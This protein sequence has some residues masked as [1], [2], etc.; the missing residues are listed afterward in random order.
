MRA[1][2]SSHSNNRR[3]GSGDSCATSDRAIATGDRAIAAGVCGT[4]PTFA[5]SQAD[6]EA[7]N[8]CATAGQS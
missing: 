6:S 3:H 4:T 8:P 1:T 5:A 7:A 2:G